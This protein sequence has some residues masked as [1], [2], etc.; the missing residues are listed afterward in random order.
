MQPSA[1]PCCGAQSQESQCKDLKDEVLNMSSRSRLPDLGAHGT[2]LIGRYGRY[3]ERRIL[4]VLPTSSTVD[5]CMTC[6]KMS[7]Q[8][9]PCPKFMNS[10]PLDEPTSA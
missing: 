1:G 3:D 10:K 8:D 6:V 9:L 4:L 7:Y 2:E 5:L